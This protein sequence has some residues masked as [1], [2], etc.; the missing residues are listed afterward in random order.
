MPSWFNP[1]CRAHHGPI[2]RVAV[3]VKPCFACPH[4]SLSCAGPKEPSLVH[5]CQS[6]ILLVFRGLTNEM[7]RPP[8]HSERI[9]AGI[10]HFVE[11]AQRAFLFGRNAD[12]GLASP[13]GA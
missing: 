6:G 11:I 8:F 3:R 2:S 9:P 13:L 5:S 12:Q 4:L 10:V 1:L 7:P